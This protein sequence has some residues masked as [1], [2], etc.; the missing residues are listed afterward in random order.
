[1]AK[2]QLARLTQTAGARH[3][4]IVK[5]GDVGEEEMP[6]VYRG[7][8][9]AETAA[10]TK[11][12]DGMEAAEA[13]PKALAEQVIELPNVFDGDK[14]VEPTEDFFRSLDTYVL[15]RIANALQADRM[16]NPT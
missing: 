15:H 11:K 7:M 10:F 1:M 9:L 2:I 16:G 6:I 12:Y 8:S 13:L 5:L 14:T 3:T 4:A